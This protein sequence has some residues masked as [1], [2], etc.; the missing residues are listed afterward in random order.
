MGDGCFTK[1][2]TTELQQI[3][4]AMEYKMRRAQ[5]ELIRSLILGDTVLSD[6]DYHRV[7]ERCRSGIKFLMM[8]GVAGLKFNYEHDLLFR[9]EQILN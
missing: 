7:E 5:A 3:T 4:I 9:T 8:G 2:N 6:R 1:R